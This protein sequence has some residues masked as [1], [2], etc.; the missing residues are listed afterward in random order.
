MW[1]VKYKRRLQE[2]INKAEEAGGKKRIDKQRAEGKL[3]ARE[4]LMRLFDANTF[5]E[6]G[7]LIESHS[8]E[9]GITSRRLPGDGVVTGYG[10][11]HGQMVYASSQDFTVNGG[12]LGEAHALKICQIMDLALDAKAPFISINDSGGA[13]IEEGICSLSGYSGIFYRNALASGV[14]PQIAV[15]LGPCAGGACYSPAMCDFV[16]VTENN[17]QM[18]ITGPAVVRETTGED[19]SGDELG[20]AE[21]HAKQSGVAHFLCKND[22]DCIDAVRNFMKYIPQ[23]NESLTKPYVYKLSEMDSNDGSGE[24]E[25]IVPDN[26]RISYDVRRVIEAF[27]DDNSFLEIQKD[28]ACNIVIGFSKLHENVIGI[29]ANQPMVLAGALDIDASDKA[30]RFIRFCDCFNIPLLSLVD[31]PGYLPGSRQ[32]HAGIIRHGAKVLYAF[33]EATV[34]R[35]TLIMRKA[36]GGS[37]C[38]MNSKNIGADMVFA[39]PI[40][41]IAV[42]G[43]EGAV[44][45]MYKKEL[46]Q[47]EN[48]VELR[49]K[50]EHEYEEKYMNPYV[51]ATHGLVDA[52]IYPEDTR[53]RL[54]EAFEAL[55]HK[56]KTNP[57]RKH[58]NIPL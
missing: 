20:G 16:F 51:A 36:F 6:V 8:L 14:I 55:Q 22:S 49:K 10:K 15:I 2:Q 54:S 24:I 56:K 31:I 5:V 40:A 37:Y 7:E 25:N 11:I 27:S 58:G 32:E 52:V 28:Y 35:V 46:K 42:M 18:F 47:A 26:M 29:V 30:A 21:V 43:A 34:P 45:I 9:L 44:G 41:E 1:D 53:K 4:R 50:L 12:T 17:S 57:W 38:A 39:W 48:L 13:R 19:V 3:L 23:N 33:S